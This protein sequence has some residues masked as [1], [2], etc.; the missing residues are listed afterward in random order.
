[1]RKVSRT[2]DVLQVIIFRDTSSRRRTRYDTKIG[3]IGR[4]T[5][6][7]TRKSRFSSIWTKKM[8]TISKTGVPDQSY[9]PDCIFIEDRR[10]SFFPL[11]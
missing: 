8:F 4:G 6:F 5:V 3:W 11:V 2:H 7:K 10:V 9:D 1:M